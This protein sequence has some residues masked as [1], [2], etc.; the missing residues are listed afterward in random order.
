MNACAA[1]TCGV[2]ARAQC[3]RA[4][5]PRYSAGDSAS[6]LWGA[7]IK[8]PQDLTGLLERL[9]EGGCAVLAGVGGGEVGRC[10]R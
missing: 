5:A 9:N 2:H 8:V 7:G 10:V 1:R 4:R 3:T 6:V